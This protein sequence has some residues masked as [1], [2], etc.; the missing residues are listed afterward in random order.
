MRR[1]VPQQ[2]RQLAKVLRRRSTDAEQQLWRLLRSRRFADVKFR[3]QVPIGSWIADFVS[4]ER[5]LVV[6]ADGGQHNE[7]RADVRRDRDL[8]ARGFRA[9]RYWNND[10]LA[11]PESV[12]EHLFDVLAN[13]PSPGFAPSGAQPPSP[14]RGE[15]KRVHG[16]G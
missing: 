7:S 8:M 14:T 6:D 3:R 11:R 9:I 2:K 16:N 4:F 5:R 15:G 12:A 13:S 10:V 1:W